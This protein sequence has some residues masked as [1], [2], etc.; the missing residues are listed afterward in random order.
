WLDL[1]LKQV[2]ELDENGDED[3]LKPAGKFPDTIRYELPEHGITLRPDYALIDSQTGSQPLILIVL[4]DPD[5]S[6][7]DPLNGDGWAT[8]P[9]E[10]MVELCRATE[11]RLGLVTNGEQW[12]LVDAPLG[13]VTSMVSWYAR[14]WPQEPVTL[15]AFVNLLGVRRFFVD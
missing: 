6:L 7:H 5:I 3:V 10:R 13:A 8:S 9:A 15:Q 11:V 14:L 2:L 12:M 1:V 4:H